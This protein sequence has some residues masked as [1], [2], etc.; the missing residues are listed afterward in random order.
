MHLHDDQQEFHNHIISISFDR[1]FNPLI[2][3][4]INLPNI[5]DLDIKLPINNQFWFIVP[6]LKQF[7]SL[8]VSSYTDSFYSQLQFLHGQEPNL[9]RLTVRQGASLPFQLS[10]FKLTNA[11]VRQLLH[12]DYYYYYYFNEEECVKLSNSL[13]VIQ[14]QILFIRVKDLESVIIL[15]KNMIN[16]RAL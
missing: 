2:Q 16:L 11:T 10:L 5:Q 1:F 4:N 15:V 8:T 13:L 6:S 3:F 9:H 14:C 12:L 7:H